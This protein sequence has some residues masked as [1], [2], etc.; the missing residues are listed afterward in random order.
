ML[1]NRYHTDITDLQWYPKLDYLL[2]IASKD[3][4]IMVI[5]SFIYLFEMFFETKN[6]KNF[7]FKQLKSFKRFGILH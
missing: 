5:Y 2:S 7:L 1:S 3:N 4:E 6:K